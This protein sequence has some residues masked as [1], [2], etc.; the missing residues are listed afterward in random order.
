MTHKKLFSFLIILLTLNS[1]K[2][3]GCTDSSAL[4]F[5]SK[6]NHDNGSCLYGPELKINGT[7][8]TIITLYS[9]YNDLGAIATNKDGSSLNVTINNPVNTSEIGYYYV[10]YT[11]TNENLTVELKRKVTVLAN[12]GQIYKGGMFFSYLKSGDEGF[13]EGEIH[14][15]LCSNSDQSAGTTWGCQGVNI[16]TSDISGAGSTNTLAIENTC[17]EANIAAKICSNLSLNGYS[18]WYLPSRTELHQMY[19]NLH[20]NG[21]GNFSITTGDNFYWSSSQFNNMSA[22]YSYFAVNDEVAGSKT[23]SFRVRAIRKF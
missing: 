13:I 9:T 15:L 17:S 8:D 11:T 18:D 6:A 5:N 22:W 19:Q 21:L 2:K 20:L 3:E 12:V 23:G 4:N 10:T 7:T 16:L 1:C 14:G